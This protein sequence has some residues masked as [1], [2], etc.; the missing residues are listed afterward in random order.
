[1]GKINRDMDQ[2]IDAIEEASGQKVR[3]ILLGPL[4]HEYLGDYFR[5]S[6]SDD[7]FGSKADV[8]AHN[9][10]LGH[11]RRALEKVAAVRKAKFIAF[12]IHYPQAI[13]SD[14]P[15]TQDGIRT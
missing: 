6:S 13:S 7:H 2:V 5:G 15:V 9:K 11:Y 10:E 12:S 4:E 3:F 8:V 14:I 1:M